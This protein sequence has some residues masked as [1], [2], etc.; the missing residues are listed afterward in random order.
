MNPRAAT[1]MGLAWVAFVAAASGQ[2]LIRRHEG[3]ADRPLNGFAVALTDLDGDG[4]NDYAL[5]GSGCVWNGSGYDGN[6]PFVDVHSGASGA[7]LF[8]IQRT[9][10]AG[11]IGYAFSD[12]GDVDGD[13]IADLLVGDPGYDDPN[14]PY[15]SEGIVRV[16]SGRDGSPLLEVIGTA[17]ND[18]QDLGYKVS[19]LD[20]VDDDGHADLLVQYSGPSCWV[21]RAISGRDGATLYEIDN[22]FELFQQPRV[23]IDRDGD[24]VRDFLVRDGGSLRACSGATGA[25]IL[26]APSP[27][28]TAAV[29]YDDLDGDGVPEVVGTL[30]WGEWIL[31]SC[32][33]PLAIWIPY[34]TVYVFSLATGQVLR[35]RTFGGGGWSPVDVIPDS[36]GDGWS[37]YLC[38]AGSA[39]LISSLAGEE[40][41]GFETSAP[42]SVVTAGDLDGDRLPDVLVSEPDF[43]DVTSGSFLSA[44]S[45][46]AGNDLWLAVDPKSAAEGVTGTLTARGDVPAGN[47]MLIAVVDV[48]GTPTFQVIALDAADATQALAITDTVPPGLAGTTMTF[49][50]FAIGRRRR[51]IDSA[52][53]TITFY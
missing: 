29:D 45:V 30:S 43:Y 21:V 53:E 25:T 2:E 44:V 22:C 10:C 27:I 37:E 32:D 7:L 24:G 8:T 19:A 46:F 41:Y 4:V 5:S 13:G 12:A 20:D 36:D 42:S 14:Q 33:C 17:S 38:G 11:F 34:T 52:L 16:H 3:T 31:P 23:R 40:L 49:Q 28:Q 9:D 50:S 26:E 39:H 35:E 1:W 48:S 6:G 51:V 47:L 15:L 18:Y